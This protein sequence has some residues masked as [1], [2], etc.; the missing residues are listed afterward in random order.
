MSEQELMQS[1]K[2][3][4]GALIAEACSTSSVPE[5]FL[6]ALIAGES[7]GKNDARRFEKNVLLNLWEVLL[8]RKAAFGSIG[9][10]D[11]LAFVTKLQNGQTRFADSLPADAFQRVDGLATSWG[12]TQIMGYHA[13]H[14]S[15]F[16]PNGLDSLRDPAKHLHFACTMLAG[17]AHQFSLDV[18]QEFDDLFRCWNTGKP[19][20]TTF[21][22]LYVSNGLTRMAIW[23]SLP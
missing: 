8:G 13:I 10:A 11:L 21:D 7:G 4:W 12:L 18:T 16:L 1:I 20:G 19:D 17:F 14:N 3:Q 6:A 9:R 22:P 5:Q 23:T 15:G 2:T